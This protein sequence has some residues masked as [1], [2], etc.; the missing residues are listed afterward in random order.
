MPGSQ[1]GVKL[2]DYQILGSSAGKPE[3]SCATHKQVSS[4][5]SRILCFSLQLGRKPKSDVALQ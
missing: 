1:G 4:M 3:V 2:G 5:L